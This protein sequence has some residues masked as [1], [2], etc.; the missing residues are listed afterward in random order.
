MRE[1][2]SHRVRLEQDSKKKKRKNEKVCSEL[3]K[4]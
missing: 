4:G 1:T 2:T 3:N